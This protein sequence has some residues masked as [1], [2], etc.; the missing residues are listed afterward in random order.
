M[1]GLRTDDLEYLA[2]GFATVPDL[3]KVVL[4][5]SRAMGN[6]KRGSDIDLALFGCTQH[7]LLDLYDLLN[8]VYP[9]PYFFDI[10][11]YESITNDALKHHIDTQGVVLRNHN[12]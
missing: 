1:Y 6:Y 4:F 7:A 12:A 9:L 2:Q 8:E 10:L 3:H 5:G 11:C